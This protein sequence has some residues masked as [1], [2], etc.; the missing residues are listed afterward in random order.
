[1]EIEDLKYI[2]K[3]QNDGFK[4]KDEAEL[5][6][7]LTGKSTSII[8]RLKRNVWIELIFTFLGGLALLAYALTLPGGSLKWT[9]IS[10]LILFGIYSFYYLKKLRLLN[11]FDPGNDHIKA[12]LQRLIQNLK[13]YLKF[14]KR[15]Y[16]ILYPVYFFLGLL[17]TAIEH[18]TTGFLNKVSNPEVMITLVLGA[19]L[20]FI[21]STWLTSW[22]LRKLYGNHLEKLEKL[23]RELE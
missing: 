17:F 18:G 2:W 20:F 11:R 10:I 5:A 3:K 12:N 9:S 21:C 15:S 8:T 1:M 13:G 16:S 23:L 19:G 14:Y 6:T 22:Y 4:P 7:M